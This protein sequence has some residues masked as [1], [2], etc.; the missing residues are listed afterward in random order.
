MSRWVR[1]KES[2]KSTGGGL[3]VYSKDH[4]D[5]SIIPEQTTCTPKLETLWIKLSLKQ[6]SPQYLGLLYK[7]PDGDLD[8]AIQLLTNRGTNLGILGNSDIM[9]IG[10]IN[11]NT[12]KP[13]EPKTCRLRDF[14][15]TLGL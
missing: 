6:T 1:T 7:P 2:G 9:L 3:L 15:H 12:M 11:I 10:D 13:R 4:L 14:Y 8:I 5:V